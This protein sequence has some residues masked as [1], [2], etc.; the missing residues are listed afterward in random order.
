MDNTESNKTGLGS[1]RL[2]GFPA[3]YPS[4]RGYI[5]VYDVSGPVLRT[6]SI[7]MS[8]AN[9]IPALTEFTLW[10]SVLGPLFTRVIVL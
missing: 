4:C 6:E 5:T 9:K 1:R 8:K 7:V 2:L 3:T 10:S